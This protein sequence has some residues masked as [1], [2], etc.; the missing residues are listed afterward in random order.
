MA[1]PV[2]AGRDPYGGVPLSKKLGIK[3]GS[4]VVLVR[5]PD[6]FEDLLAPLPD[7]AVCRRVNRGRRDLTLWFVRDREELSAEI[8][9]VV[10]RLD[11]SALWIAWPKGG[12]PPAGGFGHAAV[13]R[14]GLDQ[15]LVDSKICSMDGTWSALRFTLRAGTT[16]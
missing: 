5:P 8:A 14:A 2:P 4:V 3:A 11:G 16:S 9:S 10:Q 1:T 6:R 13:Q 7:A 15:G 12:S